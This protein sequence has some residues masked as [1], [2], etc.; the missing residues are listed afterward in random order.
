MHTIVNN[1][2]LIQLIFEKQEFNPR[3]NLSDEDFLVMT[4]GGSLL[5]GNGALRPAA[6]EAAMRD[7]VHMSFLPPSLSP[8]L[9]SPSLLFPLTPTPSHPI[10]S[11]PFSLI[12]TS[13]VQQFVQRQLTN[14]LAVG[15]CDLAAEVQLTTMKNLLDGQVVLFIE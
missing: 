14:T 9:L 6:F 12:Q 4:H 5:D 2:K 1:I 10:P 15:R 13:Q 7:Q 11:H 8:S 3:I